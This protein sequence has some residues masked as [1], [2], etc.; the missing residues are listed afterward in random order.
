[1]V[2]HG[3]LSD[4]ATVQGTVPFVA[5]MWSVSRTSSGRR[6]FSARGCWSGL[7]AGKFTDSKMKKK[8][9]ELEDP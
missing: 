8:K 1:M 6:G 7:S 5:G 9:K 2:K 3:T 4:G